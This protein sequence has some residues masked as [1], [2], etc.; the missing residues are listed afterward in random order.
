MTDIEK[1]QELEGQIRYHNDKYTNGTP[2]ISD[3]EYDDLVAELT[4]LDPTNAALLEVGATPSYGKKVKHDMVMGSLSKITFEKDANG[5]IKGDGFDEVRKW[6]KQHKEKTK[7]SMKIDGCAIKLVYVNG[8]LV[9]GATRGD[10]TT[11]SDIIDNIRAIRSIPTTIES[12]LISDYLGIDDLKCKIEVRGEGYISRKFFE[13]N[14]KGTKA[15]CRN[16]VSGSIQNQDPAKTTES[17]VQFYGYKLFLNDIEVETLTKQE[18]LVNSIRGYHGTQPARLKFVELHDGEI[19]PELV[20][21]IDNERTSYDYDTDGMVVM[22]DKIS[23]RDSYGMAGKC[24]KGAFAFKFKPEQAETVL[25]SITWQAGR[26]GKLTP[27]GELKPVQLAGTNVARCSL[28]NLSEVK[29][30]KIEIGDR[31]LVQKSGDIIPQIVRVIEHKESGDINYPETC[32]T[33][34]TYT[35]SDGTN[36]NCYNEECGSK[37][38]TRV[39]HYLSVLKIKEVGPGLIQALIDAGKIT[40]VTSIYYVSESD[41]MELPRSGLRTAQT[42]MNAILS[43]TTLKL[44]TFLNSLAIHNLGGTTSK[45]LAKHFKTLDAVRQAE[46]NDMVGIPDI[47]GTTAQSIFD[48]L[49]K[50]ADII[51]ELNEL[52]DIKDFESKE[53]IFT[54][55][56]FCCTGKVNLK[57]SQ[58]QEMIEEAG[59]EYKS[60][61]KGLNFLVIGENAVQSKI[62]KAKSL[63]ASVISEDEFLD[64][65]KEE[66]IE[67]KEQELF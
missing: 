42:Y 10:G 41:V 47:G 2:E 15:N 54:G 65:L 27:V 50:K 48:G 22:I 14:L 66:G 34:G 4:K 3:V 37:L 38:L 56:R 45:A 30:L 19:T 18:Q 16:A 46:I 21:K 40:D 35:E 7:W 60:I 17:D 8:K 25:E 57:R 52:L 13:E 44:E 12:K 9:E 32:P 33:C 23:E 63:G 49:R 67:K 20:E 28:H 29:R 64:M 55:K 6:Y 36:V 51:N 24:P 62:D 39:C 61:S 1:I 53:G 58:I 5:N 11:G 59:G 43:V 31:V 26:T